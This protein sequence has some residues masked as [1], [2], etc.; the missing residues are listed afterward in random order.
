VEARAAYSVTTLHCQ[1]ALPPIAQFAAVLSQIGRDDFR[2]LLHLHYDGNK[3]RCLLA[4]IRV[5]KGFGLEFARVNCVPV[6]NSQRLPDNVV[7]VLRIRDLHVASSVSVLHAAANNLGTHLHVQRIL[8]QRF[9]QLD[10]LAGFVHIRE[11]DVRVRDRHH[12]VCLRSVKEVEGALPAGK[13]EDAVLH[14]LLTV[15]K[16]LLK[17]ITGPIGRLIP[18]SWRLRPQSG[19]Q[20]ARHSHHPGSSRMPRPARGS[21][22]SQRNRPASS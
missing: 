11:L 12:R 1:V 21:E 19:R 17:A 16:N 4:P 9:P 15:Y 6:H 18:P 5:L 8:R 10:Y 20:E 7:A 14:P 13:I 3:Y 2:E 22:G